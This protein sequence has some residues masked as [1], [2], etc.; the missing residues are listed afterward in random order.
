MTMKDSATNSYTGFDIDV[1]TQLAADLGV[2]LELVPTEWKTLVDISGPVVVPHLLLHV[3]GEGRENA[4]TNREGGIIHGTGFDIADVIVIPV[5]VA[6][7]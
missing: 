1:M 6:L 5:N 2:E 7:D 4:A 3:V